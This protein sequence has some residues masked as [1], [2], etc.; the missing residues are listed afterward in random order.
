MGTYSYSK[1][2]KIGI[3]VFL[4]LLIGVFI[5][6]IFM[7]FY[8]EK[9][10]VN[11]IYIITPISIFLILL[12]FLGIR[13]LYVSKVIIT[14]SFISA[15]NVLFNRKLRIEEISGY[16]KVEY[17]ILIY[18]KSRF[19][20]R[21]KISDY[22]SDGGEILFWL[23][24]NFVDLTLK[25]EQKEEKEFYRNSE[26]GISVHEKEGVLN[27]ATKTAK[28]IKIVSISMTLLMLFLTKYFKNEYFVYVLVFIPLLIIFIVISFKGIIKYEEKK[29][30]EKTIYPSVLW[31]FL[32]P[33]FGL[34]LYVMFAINV[35]K[36]NAVWEVLAYSTILVFFLCV[37]GSKEYKLENAK[38]IGTFISLFVFSTMYSFSVIIIFNVFFDTSETSLHQA[39]ILEKRISKGKTTNYY[40]KLNHS[41]ISDEAREFDVSKFIYN[42]KNIGDS[43]HIFVN[44]GKLNI[45]YYKIE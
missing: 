17:Y 2:F 28:W 20:K 27:K 37:Y 36:Y 30:D 8:D 23:Q 43:V 42:S 19:K 31:G 7:P 45:P 9:T 39:P 44:Q 38:T 41:N 18:P 34:L 5:A 11:S 16:K 10:S 24:D 32:A 12:C 14:K 29:E 21:I 25:V 3:T 40:F 15:K 35:L 4:I 13:D 1:G 22:I 26:F 33:I 6:L